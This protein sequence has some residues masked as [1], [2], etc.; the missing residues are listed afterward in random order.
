MASQP[1]ETQRCG[2]PE[3]ALAGF[4]LT[5]ETRIC[6]LS[7]AIGQEVFEARVQG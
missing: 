6:K 4:A 7:V 3:R 2:S 1:R 5:L